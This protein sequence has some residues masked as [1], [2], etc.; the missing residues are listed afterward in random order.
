MFL[1]ERMIGVSIYC[2]LLF[3]VF[4]MIKSGKIRYKKVL[5]IYIVLLS[6]MAYFYVPYKTADLYRILKIVKSFSSYEFS[7]FAQ[8]FLVGTSSPVAYFM[9]WV[10][11]RAGIARFLPVIVCFI[12]YGI[13]FH[14]V[15]IFS[16]KYQIS[17]K[18]IALFV[19]FI[20]STGS[21]IMIISNIR[22]MLALSLICYCYARETIEKKFNLANMVVYILAMLIHN[23]AVVLVALRIVIFV[24][25]KKKNLSSYI[26][27]TIVIAIIAVVAIKYGGFLLEAVSEKAISYMSEKKYS[28]VWDY[29]LGTIILL[30]ELYILALNKKMRVKDAIIDEYRKY[31]IL[32]I[33][34]A[35]VF[36]GEFSIYHRILTY[37]CP[38]LIT[39]VFIYAMDR[40]KTQRSRRYNFIFVLSTLV[41]LLSCVRGSM[42]SLKFFVL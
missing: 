12:V 25:R 8:N 17:K 24:V 15:K 14:I 10:F 39:P 9:Y 31:L 33:A 26:L 19:F 41:L 42:S 34:L 6:I 30:I 35:V 28:Y 37:F 36:C 22:T 1:L 38:M 13:I 16:D 5:N 3:W 23:L 29:I 20:M 18:N 4:Q 27:T 21:Y 7:D 32:S 2:I 40:I 11:G